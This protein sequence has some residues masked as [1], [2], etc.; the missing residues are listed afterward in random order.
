MLMFFVQKETAIDTP[1]GTSYIT[2]Y[3]RHPYI[4]VP[5]ALFNFR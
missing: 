1:R 2:T 3:H 4:C 5:V